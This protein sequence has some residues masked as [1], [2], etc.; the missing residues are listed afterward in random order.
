[1]AWPYSTP[2][3]GNLVGKVKKTV[4]SWKWQKEKKLFASV[5]GL[6]RENK[7]IINKNWFNWSL[8]EKVA[9]SPARYQTRWGQA[10]SD[11][12]PGLF[13]SGPSKWSGGESQVPTKPT[14]FRGKSLNSWTVN[15]GSKTI[16]CKYVS[17]LSIAPAVHINL[18][19]ALPKFLGCSFFLLYCRS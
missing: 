16:R 18:K 12:Y 17:L 19:S 11:L 13:P 14:M 8:P 1:M 6:R 10:R 15:S 9:N 3:S 4:N 2:V 7:L 5:W